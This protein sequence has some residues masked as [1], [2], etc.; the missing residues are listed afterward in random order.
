MTPKI[1]IIVLLIL[2]LPALLF[3][4]QGRFRL[5]IERPESL[6]DTGEFKPYIIL[7]VLATLH[8]SIVWLEAYLR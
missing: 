3:W 8:V 1:D 4:W 7:L 5:K 6:P 2:G